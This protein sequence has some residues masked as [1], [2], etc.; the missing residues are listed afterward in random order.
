MRGFNWCFS[1]CVIWFRLIMIMFCKGMG[2]F[3][4][5]LVKTFLYKHRFWVMILVALGLISFVVFAYYPRMSVVSAWACAGNQCDQKVLLLHGEVKGI[6]SDWV[7]YRIGAELRKHPDIK[8]V[9]ISS[10]GGSSAQ[11]MEIADIIY[12]HA[13]NTCLASKYKPDDGAEDI[14][15]LCQ[16]ACIWMILAGRERILYDKYLVMGFHAA[17]NQTGGRADKDL[18]M[19]NERVAIY[20][21]LRPKAESEAWKLAGLTWWAF[22][23]GATSE[24][25][26][27]TANE[28]NRKYPYFTDDRSLPAPPDRS[29]GMQGPYEVKRSFK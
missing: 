4:S 23:Q 10:Q 16:S 12:G 17:R 7:R 2:R 9:C 20:T 5:E 19:Y 26:D 27:C 28:V 25:K 18:D 1:W 21:Q 8:I 3:L 13:F 29:C 11:A 24:T 14:P 6:S 15:G 22:H